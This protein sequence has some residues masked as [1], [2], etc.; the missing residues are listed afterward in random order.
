VR[1][2]DAFTSSLDD[3]PQPPTHPVTNDSVSQSLCGDEAK[4]KGFRQIFVRHISQNKELTPDRLTRSTDPLEIRPPGNP[5][6]AGEFHDPETGK[7]ARAT[8]AIA[9]EKTGL[10]AVLDSVTL[11][12][13]LRSLGNEAL[14]PFLAAALDQVT[15]GF[16]CHAGTEAVLAFAGTLRWLIGPFHL[17]RLKNVLLLKNAAPELLHHAHDPSKNPCP[18]SLA[19]KRPEGLQR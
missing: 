15:T 2:E 12:V 10:P 5:P 7:K 8:A 16:C 18:V 13:D 17:F 11:V 19:E 1:V 14:T 6:G 3:C 4:A 9:S